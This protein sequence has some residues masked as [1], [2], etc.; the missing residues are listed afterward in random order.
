M[1]PAS[2]TLLVLSEARL[3]LGGTR[4]ERLCLAMMTAAWACMELTAGW[5]REEGPAG[6]REEVGVVLPL[7]LQCIRE[8]SSCK[9]VCLL[10]LEL[11][12][13]RAAGTGVPVWC[14]LNRELGVVAGWNNGGCDAPK[15]NGLG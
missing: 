3:L 15:R 4:T 1:S 7:P 11:D 8:E 10:E 5:G 14:S 9:G 12:S 6:V 13:C 2:A